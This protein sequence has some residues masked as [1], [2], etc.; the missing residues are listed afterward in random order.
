MDVY[1]KILL[2]LYEVTGGKESES[3]D[4]VELVK[5]EGF[6]PSFDDIH[7][8]MSRAG[9]IADSGRGNKV[10]ITHWGVKEARKSGTG[11]ED[12]ASELKKLAKRFQEEVKELLVMA[13]ELGSAPGS[14][15]LKQLERQFKTVSDGLEE[16]RSRI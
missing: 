11:G 15:K 1:H 8:Q 14:D 10:K 3:V 13:E 4:F 16:I 9:W 6:F 7:R 2:K 12:S 5:K